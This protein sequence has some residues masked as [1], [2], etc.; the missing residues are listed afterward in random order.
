[1]LPFRRRIREQA[2]K[3]QN[4][5]KKDRGRRK[6]LLPFCPE[7]ASYSRGNNHNIGPIYPDF[8]SKKNS[9]IAD[10][11]YKPK[12]NI[13]N[14]DYLQVLAYMLRFDAKLGYYLYPNDEENDE[15]NSE[16]KQELK[17]NKGSTFKKNVEHRDDICVIKL[18]LKIPQ[19][20]YN[21]E[22]FVNQ[23]N[24]SEQ[25]FV[26]QMNESEKEFFQ[27]FSCLSSC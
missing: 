21:Y 8:I 19:N 18:G 20:A 14:K 16:C 13:G 22:E 26:N 9:V 24:K 5:Y 11:K 1:M 25:E 7:E 10:A 3:F 2:P 15:E 17:L 6:S 27:E 12:K 4:Q 23:M